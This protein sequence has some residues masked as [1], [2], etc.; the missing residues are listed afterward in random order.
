MQRMIS[1]RVAPAT[2]CVVFL[3]TLS[4]LFALRV[5][6]QAVQRWAPQ[7]FLPPFDEFQG[8]SLSYWFLLSA[9]M[10]IL[11]AMAL[12]SWRAQ[13]GM[14]APNRRAA[15][16]LAWFGGLYMAASLGR[17]VVGLAIPAAPDWFR[18]WIPAIFHVV[19]AGFVLT[20]AVYHRRGLRIMHGEGRQ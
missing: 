3:W 10:L 7:P 9:Q 8:S 1:T 4:L 14:L 13:S 12:F 18:T 6:G 15:R 17:I 5:L 19:L 2:G 20:L 11:S 16:V